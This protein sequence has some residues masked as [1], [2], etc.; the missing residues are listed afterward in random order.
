MNQPV[1]IEGM[2][3]V[4]PQG[5]VTCTDS[6]ACDGIPNHITQLRILELFGHRRTGVPVVF[7]FD[8]AQH[9][10]QHWLRLYAA[11]MRCAVEQSRDG[12]LF[13]HLQ[14]YDY[15]AGKYW[16]HCCAFYYDND[17]KHQV[18]IDP[19]TASTDTS[20]GDMMRLFTQQHLWDTTGTASVT[21][22]DLDISAGSVTENIQNYFVSPKEGK[23]DEEPCDLSGCCATVMILIVLVCLRF[24][25]RDPQVI[26]DAMRCVMRHKRKV[27]SDDQLFDFLLRLRGWHEIINNVRLSKAQFQRLLHITRPD[28]DTTSVCNA[29][30]YGADGRVGVCKRIHHGNFAWCS[31]HTPTGLDGGV[32]MPHQNRWPV[33]FIPG[34][35]VFGEVEVVG[36][37]DASWRT[38]GWRCSLDTMQHQLQAFLAHPSTRGLGVL[39]FINTT[40]DDIEDVLVRRL[41]AATWQSLHRLPV[42]LVEM[43]CVQTPPP[44]ASLQPAFQTAVL[45]IVPFFAWSR[46]YVAVCSTL[47][48]MV[49][50]MASLQRV[51]DFA[52][53]LQTVP[54]S[55][56]AYGLYVVVTRPCHLR[57]IHEHRDAP[58]LRRGS[59]H[60]VFDEAPLR[61]ADWK[62][63]VGFI[64][65]RPPLRHVAPLQWRSGPVRGVPRSWCVIRDCGV[66]CS[67]AK[68]RSSIP[69]GQRLHPPPSATRLLNSL[70]QSSGDTVFVEPPLQKH[71]LDEGW[72]VDHADVLKHDVVNATQRR[73]A[74]Q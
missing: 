20:D 36:Y 2:L 21:T 11:P 54:E 1:C 72:I 8:T 24:R 60:F 35:V 14:D 44:A 27:S 63:M 15:T 16:G 7:N 50:N 40:M 68:H 64:Q 71:F 13:I 73:A 46:A 66:Y 45:H 57:W 22:V 31:D 10:A 4:V 58:L 29:V 61:S 53:L 38:D 12:Y 41:P 39:R 17:R 33:V 19:S 43:L 37:F 5:D 48:Y 51:K 52:D 74:W 23:P 47:A 9:P 62:L 69:N 42:L 30:V 18:F 49:V 34:F 25:S 6:I 56:Y 65:Q 55:N 67:T 59:I 70:W 26:V 3:A 28:D 32:W